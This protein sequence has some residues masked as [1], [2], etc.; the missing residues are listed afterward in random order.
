MDATAAAAAASGG[1]HGGMAATQFRI[2]SLLASLDAQQAAPPCVR[3]RPWE[4]P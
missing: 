1:G 4:R 3:L 2:K